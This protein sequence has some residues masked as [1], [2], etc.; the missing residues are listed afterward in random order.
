L[1]HHKA[2]AEEYAH[3]LLSYTRPNGNYLEHELLQRGLLWGIGKLAR[4]RPD[5]LR[6]AVPLLTPYLRSKDPT[7]RA[8][9]ARIMGFLGIQGARPDLDRLTGDLSEVS[10]W[11]DGRL[12]KGRVKDVAE[13]A[14]ARLSFV[15]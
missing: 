15:Q 14:L 10:F 9:A 12:F 2:L 7:V 3:I 4:T 6:N 13:G 1:V 5:F 8:L 11:D